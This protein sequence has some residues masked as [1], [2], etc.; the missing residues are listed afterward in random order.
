MSADQE[1]LKMQKKLVE[2]V[3]CRA[4]RFRETIDRLPTVIGS[5]K[6]VTIGERSITP[7]NEVLSD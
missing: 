2:E 7:Y 5:R 1:E 6:P 3:N 4:L